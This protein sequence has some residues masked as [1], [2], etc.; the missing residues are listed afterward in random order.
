MI[1]VIK[2]LA[3]ILAL[4]T[5]AKSYL[6]FKKK[7]ETLIMFVFWSVIWIIATTL[8]VYP[9]LIERIN[10]FTKDYTLTLGSV[11]SLA[12]IFMLYII[13]RV[14][15]KAARIEYQLNNLARKISLNQL[16]K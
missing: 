8:V 9:L 2:L 3:V 14:Y 13:Y 5:I 1:I 7:Q 12:F 4:T 16:D 15:A 6:D 11:V 10:Q